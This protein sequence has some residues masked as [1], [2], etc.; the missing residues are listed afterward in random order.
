PHLHGPLH[1]D[2]RAPH[3]AQIDELHGREPGHG[4]DARAARRLG[5]PA[6]RQDRG[7]HAVRHARD[8]RDERPGC[9]EERGAEAPAGRGEGRQM[10]PWAKLAA[11]ALSVA[12]GIGLTLTLGHREAGATSPSLVVTYSLQ[13]NGMISLD[14]GRVTVQYS[15]SGSGYQLALSFR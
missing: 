4:G 7:A 15:A 13:Y 10:R 9:R 14:V 3:L 12:F 5:R 1:P 11:G 2:R 8:R 6:A